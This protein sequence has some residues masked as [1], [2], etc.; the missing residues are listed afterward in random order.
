MI[1]VLSR[2]FNGCL[3]IILGITCAA[4]LRA[5]EF[6]STFRQGVGGY[7]GTLDTDLN[8][9]EPAR[10]QG[11]DDQCLADLNNPIAQALIRFENIFGTGPGQVPPGATILSATL[12]L[13]TSNLGDLCRGFRVLVPWD[14]TTTTWD[15]MTNGISADDVEMESVPLFELDSGAVGDIF[16]FDVTTTVSD[17]YAG[18]YPNYGWGITNAGNDGWQFNSSEFST[19]GFRPILTIV[20]DSPCVPITIV[21]QPANTNVNEGD[22]VTFTVIAGGTGVNYQWL[23][24][25]SPIQDATNANYTISRVFRADEANYSVVLNNECSGPITSANALLNVIEDNTPPTILAAYGTNDNVTLFVIF[26]EIVTNLADPANYSVFLTSDPGSQLTVSNA[27]FADPAATEGRVAVL[28]LD[29][30]TPWVGG[31][32]YSVRASAVFDLFGN[33]IDPA[34]STPISLYNDTIFTI[35]TDQNWFFLDPRANPPAGWNTRT[36]NESGW[37]AG[38]ALLGVEGSA[39]PEPL[40]TP[41]VLG[42]ITYYFRTHFTY[43]GPPGKGVLRFRTVLDDSAIIHVNGVE[44]QRVRMNPGPAEYVTQGAGNAIDNA[45]YEGPYTVAVTNLVTG[46]NVIA[47]EVHQIGTGSS[48]IV[49]GMDL[50]AVTPAIEPITIV[51]QPAGTNVTE[52]AP[53]TLRVTVNGSSPQYQWFLNGV[54]IPGATGPSYVVPASDC[55]LHGGQYRVVVSNDVPSSVT[56]QTVTVNVA[57]D[58][59]PPAVACVYGTNDV[60]VVLF[61]EN[62]TMEW[63]FAPFNFVIRPL[64]G[65]TALGTGSVTNTSGTNFGNTVLVMIDPSTPRDPSVAYQIEISGV[66]DLATPGNVIAPVTFPVPFHVTAPL[67]ASTAQWRYNITGTDLGAA[68]RAASYNDSTWPLGA[69]LFDAKRPQRTNVSGVPIATQTTLSNAANTAQIPTH[70]FRTHFNYSGPSSATLEL[71]AMVDD[72]TVWYL[73]GV[74]VFRNR[75]PAAPAVINYATLANATVN[76]ATNEFFYACVDNLI[77]GD[78]VLAVEVHQVDLT[79][80]DLTFGVQVSTYAVTP[81]APEARL[82][83]TRGTGGQ[84]NISWTGSGVLQESSNLSTHPN[85][86]SNVAGVVGNSYNTTIAAGNRF[87]RVA[88]NP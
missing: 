25:G 9:N 30:S 85:G 62:V 59:T 52:P 21:T 1:K 70:Y 14:E 4:S 68:W 55:D 28:T 61:S 35:G 80:S 33:V 37:G 56:S 36:F 45:V 82:T 57:C 29:P 27:S 39:L 49:W 6:S 22:S 72:G 20:F 44:V 76:D 83:I 8:S 12:T 78:N 67:L 79:S 34:G 50:S 26:S 5:A 75:M 86:W 43:D 60:V 77:N 74:E 15:T 13:R 54:E 64:G 87:F 10:V 47:V 19:V 58:V 84:I 73:N 63:D 51:T 42:G 53:F 71:K 17:W 40:R 23:R 16:S 31:Q 81:P 65:G 3:A 66:Q 69:A 38:P 2:P 32:A 48:D 88:P 24:D 11:G 46:D 7:T 41:L 18:V